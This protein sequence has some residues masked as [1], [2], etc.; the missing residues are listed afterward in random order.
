MLVARRYVIGGR[1][2][3]VGFRNFTATAAAREGV[4]GWVRNLTDG[5]VEVM[6]EGAAEAVERFEQQL[7]HGPRGARVDDVQ[8]TEAPRSGR[9]AGFTVR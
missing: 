1:V 4:T 9:Y 7:R 8:V 2:Q 3:R 5:C 6:A